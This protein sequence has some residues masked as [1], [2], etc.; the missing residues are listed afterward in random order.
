MASAVDSGSNE[1]QQQ[2]PL[3]T[4]EQQ[5]LRRVVSERMFVVTHRT[6]YRGKIERKSF[7]LR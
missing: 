4:V 6:L 5:P 3:L 7:M 1:R 2:F